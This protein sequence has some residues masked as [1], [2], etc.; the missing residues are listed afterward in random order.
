[1]RDVLAKKAS[2]ISSSKTAFDVTLSNF[3]MPQFILNKGNLISL[4]MMEDCYKDT[5][6]VI[7]QFKFFECKVL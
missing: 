2:K 5:L 3:S 1:M 6:I 4:S 7:K